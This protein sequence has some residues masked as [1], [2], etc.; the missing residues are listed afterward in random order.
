MERERKG[1]QR[2][3]DRERGEKKECVKGMRREQRKRDRKRDGVEK[4]RKVEWK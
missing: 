4:M 1:R 2:K 3:N